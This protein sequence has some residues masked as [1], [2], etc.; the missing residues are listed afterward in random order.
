MLS[1]MSFMKGVE[2]WNWF[3]TELVGSC[4]GEINVLAGVGEIYD[5]KFLKSRLL[6]KL[7]K[8]LIVEVVSQQESGEEVESSQQWVNFL[9]G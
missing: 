3:K 7:L 5:S 4:D 2:S 6:K 9:V 8:K 1:G